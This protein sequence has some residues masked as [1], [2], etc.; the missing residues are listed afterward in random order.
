[1][2]IPPG[3]IGGSI[4]V[5]E[6]KS[7]AR[8]REHVERGT[9]DGIMDN[10]DNDAHNSA[11]RPVGSGKRVKIESQN[12]TKLHQ[13]IYYFVLLKS[14]NLTV[15]GSNIRDYSTFLIIL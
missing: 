15:S 3:D 13:K 11:T 8:H 14:L 2:T 10:R 9:N 4:V 5:R 12:F 6:E 7:S 1:M